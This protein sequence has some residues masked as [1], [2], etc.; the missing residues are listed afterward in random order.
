MIHILE[1]LLERPWQRPGQSLSLK[2]WRRIVLAMQTLESET[3][4]ACLVEK[5]SHIPLIGETSDKIFMFSCCFIAYMNHTYS[6]VVTNANH[7]IEAFFI[8]NLNYIVCYCIQS[9]GFR[10]Q[11]PGRL[12]WTKHIRNYD[13]IVLGAKKIDLQVPVVRT[14]RKTVQEQECW[15]GFRSNRMKIFVLQATLDDNALVK[16]GIHIDDGTKML[17][18]SAVLTRGVCIA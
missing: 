13:S 15:I 17:R 14:R 11:W 5:E 16:G 6:P 7:S 1:L 4:E 8:Q 2:V 12:S 10:I 9:K 18:W 3:R